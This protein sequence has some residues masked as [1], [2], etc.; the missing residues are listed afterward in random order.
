MPPIRK[1]KRV[2]VIWLFPVLAVMGVVVLDELFESAEVTT[3]NSLLFLFFLTGKEASAVNEN[4]KKAIKNDKIVVVFFITIK[5]FRL[6]L[7][8]YKFLNMKKKILTIFFIILSLNIFSQT[9]QKFEYQYIGVIVLESKIL[10]SYKIDFNIEKDSIKGY[11]YTDLGGSNETKSILEGIYDKKTNDINFVERDILYTKSKINGDEFCFIKL[12]GKL[13]IKKTKSILNADFI[14]YYP[15]N[16][17]CGNGRIRL[18][19]E[20]YAYKRINNL[21]KKVKKK[22]KI[23][24]V[25]KE[26]LKPENF[27]KKFSETNISSGEE[28]SVFMYAN[29][30]RMEIWD[31]GKEDGDIISIELNGKV[32]LKNYSVKK[33]KKILRILLSK[34]KNSLKIT[35]VNAGEL[36]TNTAKIKLYDTRRTY[37]VLTNLEV[38]KSALINIYKNAK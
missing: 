25:V 15:D 10:Y 5:R 23:D 8:K 9:N 32:I 29:E 11:S 4:I 30:L 35:T 2:A 13:K 19:G 14:G 18:L 16:T 26:K 17:K 12:E 27:L 38:G 36:D 7:F 33:V 24:S 37:E 34:G 6:I 20:N 31:Y 22:K 1:A 21:Y 28:V 3:V